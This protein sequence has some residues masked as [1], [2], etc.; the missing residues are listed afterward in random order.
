M[1]KYFAF[2]KMRFL[3]GLQYRA[4]ALGGLLCQ[5]FWGAM[6]ILAFRAF[7]ESDPAAFPM[8]FQDTSSYIWLQQAL[9]LLISLNGLDGEFFSVIQNG[10]VAY[11]L[12]RPVGVYPMW[13]ARSAASRVSAALLRCWPTLLI[14]ALIPAP[15]G[16][17]APQ[18][19]GMFF[20]FLLSLFLAVC[21]VTALGMIIYM[22]TFHTI[23]P[24]GV[25]LIA[26]AIS[27]FCM[28]S[29]IPLPFF[30][31]G[32]R[33]MMELLPFS[34]MA[35]VPL[36][37]YSGDLCGEEMLWKIALQAFWT[38]ALVGIGK[39]LERR[40]MKYVVIQGG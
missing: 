38:V 37:I 14:A 1:K 8:R 34:S 11:E 24:R 25:R 21:V 15:Y 17:A 36:R 9:F 32:I 5:F 39:A 26:I 27:D 18:S 30:P 40:E 13:C 28:G 4:A 23:S 35:D 29:V 7:Y 22:I 12:C 20:W 10:N 31:D 19:V 2:F 6:A 33:R 3:M 16:L